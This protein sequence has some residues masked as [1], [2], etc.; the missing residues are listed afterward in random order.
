MKEIRRWRDS[1][2]SGRQSHELAA[3]E[4]MDRAATINSH[5]GFPSETSS[6]RSTVSRLNDPAGS[7]DS[8]DADEVINL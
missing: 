1:L 4:L 2:V 5:A 7:S 6:L 3:L 8:D